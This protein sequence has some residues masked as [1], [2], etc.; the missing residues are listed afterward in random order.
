MVES[1]NNPV[2]L[3]DIKDVLASAHRAARGYGFSTI[4]IGDWYVVI[5]PEA[6]LDETINECSSAMAD[7]LM[8]WVS[9]TA[10]GSKRQDFSRP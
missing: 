9:P 8:A 3:R 5:P 1:M 2:L 7:S 4:I 6:T 10:K